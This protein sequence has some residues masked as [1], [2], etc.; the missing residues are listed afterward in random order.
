[1]LCAALLLGGSLPFA[2]PAAAQYGGMGG[3]GGVGAMSS[4]GA[5]GGSGGIG[6]PGGMR[7]PMGG[8]GGQSRALAPP[9]PRLRPDTGPRLDAGALLCRSLEDLRRRAALQANPAAAAGPRPDCRT[10]PS[11]VPITVVSRVGPGATQVQLG[12]PGAETGWTDAWL[13]DRGGMAQAPAS[14]TRRSP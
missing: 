12:T 11:S 13:P 7:G 14:A 10:V 3:I 1:M 8:S 4:M 9:P 2:H 6:G 5:M